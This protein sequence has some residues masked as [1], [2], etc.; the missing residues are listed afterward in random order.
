ME[1]SNI[2]RYTL[3]STERLK[4]RKQIETLFQTGEAFSVYPLRVIYGLT[5]REAVSGPSLAG[6]SVPKKK[7]KLAVHR[8]RIK[9]LIKEC[10]R[11]QKHELAPALLSH[12]QAHIFFI[13][14]GK[15]MPVHADIYKSV[16]KAISILHKKLVQ[17][18]EH[19]S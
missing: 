19:T 11:V 12:Q 9:R 5:P 10:W 18:N 4:L 2:Q 14:T 6:F 13:F 7:M 17:A 16:Q 1:S 15:E 8:N 3:H